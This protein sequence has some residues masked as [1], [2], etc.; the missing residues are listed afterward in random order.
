MRHMRTSFIVALLLATFA[1]AQVSRAHD[2]A[3]GLEKANQI[4]AE[5]RALIEKGHRAEGAKTIAQAWRIRAEIWGAE[6]M[7]AKS[8]PRP[9]IIALKEKIERVRAASN[10][11]EK[12]GHELKKAGK[13]EDAEKKMEESGKLWRH[14]DEMQK[15]LEMASLGQYKDRFAA[16]S[17]KSHDGNARELNAEAARAHEEVAQA[18][19]RAAR[20]EA[21]GKETEAKEAM[22]QAKQL[23][24]RIRTL[25][26]AQ[27]EAS[28]LD[29]QPTGGIEAKLNALQKQME[30]MREM[31]EDL[32][33]RIGDQNK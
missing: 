4:E 8:E 21:E 31:V 26:A 25:L 32:R 16:V 20:A 23:K 2:P 22:I 9:E 18:L 12:E 6:Q 11:A 28:T 13:L 19:A 3:V 30:A 24:E 15:K 17:R 1:F 27:R 10:D 33:K 7:A 29:G 14:A 5:G